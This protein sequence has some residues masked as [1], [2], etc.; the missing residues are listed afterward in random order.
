MVEVW[1]DVV[2]YEGI[3]QI[4][5]LGNV[6]SLNRYAKTKCGNERFFKGKVLIKRLLKGYERVELNNNGVAKQWSVHR[7]V[8]LAFIPNPNNLPVINHKDEVKTNNNIDNLEWCTVKYNNNYGNRNLKVS[9]KTRGKKRPHTC[10][11]N[12]FR[13]KVVICLND[14]KVYETLTK[15]AKV[16]GC[17]RGRISEVCNKKFS[18]TH[19]YKFMYYD[20]YLNSKEVI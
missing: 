11:K 12:H 15:A 18:Q 4:S 3:Y 1:K 17:G 20:E 5:N 19:G 2:G 7:L 13:S 9:L 14:L 16:Y 6:K 10:G 8:A